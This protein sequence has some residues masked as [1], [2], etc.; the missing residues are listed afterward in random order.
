VLLNRGLNGTANNPQLSIAP[1]GRVDVAFYRQ[2]NLDTADAFWAFS[3]DGGATFVS[4]QLNERPID[5]RAGYS[6]VLRSGGVDHYTPGIASTDD[7]A[8][9]V[10]SDTRDANAVTNTQDVVLRT[11]DVNRS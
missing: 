9:A 11:L 2:P 4:R 7:R 3:T 5:R 1:N 8:Y 6:P 10:W